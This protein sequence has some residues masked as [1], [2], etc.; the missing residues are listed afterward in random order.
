MTGYA[1]RLRAVALQNTSIRWWDWAFKWIFCFR[2]RENVWRKFG[3]RTE[4]GLVLMENQINL[5]WCMSWVMHQKEDGNSCQIWFTK[6]FPF[7]ES[8]RTGGTIFLSVSVLHT[9]ITKLQDY[10]N[11]RRQGRCRSEGR[12]S[13]QAWP[14][15]PTLKISVLHNVRM[16]CIKQN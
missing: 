15:H 9:L 2:G 3:W 11:R 1:V 16:Y 4:F 14:V 13:K 6:G 7:A 5:T 10:F 8:H 12:E